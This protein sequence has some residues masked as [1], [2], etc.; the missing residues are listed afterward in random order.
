MTPGTTLLILIGIFVEWSIVKKKKT[1]TIFIQTF[2]EKT[3]IASK[4][5][6]LG[7]NNS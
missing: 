3:Q 1:C 7:R 4:Y 6:E 5:L 2:I